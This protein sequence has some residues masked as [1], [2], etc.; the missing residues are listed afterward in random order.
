MIPRR[1]KS[2]LN[3]LVVNPQFL[4]QLSAIVT[5]QP[6]RQSSLNYCYS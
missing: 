3:H 4:Q 1:L 5:Q 6:R 2:Y